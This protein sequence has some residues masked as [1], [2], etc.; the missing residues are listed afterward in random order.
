MSLNNHHT[1]QE[2]N[3]IKELLVMINDKV[4]QLEKRIEKIEDNTETIKKS[5]SN[6]DNHIS[7]IDGVYDSVKSP[8]HRAMNLVSFRFGSSEIEDAPKTKTHQ[9]S[10]ILNPLNQNLQ[11]E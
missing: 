2:L 4:L 10:D 8:F 9:I 1:N 3:E 5:A 11:I 7:F 6:M